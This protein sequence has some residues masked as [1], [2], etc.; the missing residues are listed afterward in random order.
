MSVNWTFH[1]KPFG[2][3]ELMKPSRVRPI[4]VIEDTIITIITVY[5]Y[6]F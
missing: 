6:Y 2:T 4:F 3:D 5:T 1:S